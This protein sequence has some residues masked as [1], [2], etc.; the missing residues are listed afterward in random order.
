MTYTGRLRPRLAC[1]GAAGRA[2][3]SPP[4]YA[5]ADAADKVG[6]RGKL[7]L[8]PWCEL[9]CFG[10]AVAYLQGASISDRTYRKKLSSS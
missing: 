8:A 3:P 4:G 5:S 9:I 10:E 1:G 7:E 2:G 6:V